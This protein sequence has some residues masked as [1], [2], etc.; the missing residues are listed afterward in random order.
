MNLRMSF[1]KAMRRRRHR[2]P[3]TQCSSASQEQ[4]RKAAALRKPAVDLDTARKVMWLIIKII[5]IQD[6]TDP[7]KWTEKAEWFLKYKDLLVRWYSITHG[8]K[9]MGPGPG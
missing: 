5:N 2:S 9:R 4:G 3:L 6:R 1:N 7:E 8:R